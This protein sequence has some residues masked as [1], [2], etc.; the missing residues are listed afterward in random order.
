MLKMKDLQPGDEVFWNDPD[1][2][3]CSD[4]CTVMQIMSDDVVR[5]TSRRGS[6]VEAFISE[7]S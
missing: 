1:N 4:Y 3:L 5:L 2:G 6:E 7:L